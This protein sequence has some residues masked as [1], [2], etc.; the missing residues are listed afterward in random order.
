MTDFSCRTGPTFLDGVLL[1]AAA[2][3]DAGLV[4]RGSSCVDE[5]VRQSL[6]P[7]G[8]AGCLETL[9]HGG[10]LVLTMDP[11]SVS[12]MGTEERV[13]RGVE[14]LVARGGIRLVLLATLS[15]YHLT[16][17][18]LGPL[19]G[20]LDARLPDVDVQALSTRLL[21]RDHHDAFRAFY[22]GL[23]ARLVA[24]GLETPIP[25]TVGI[26]GAPWLRDG[27]DSRGDIEELTRLVE[28]LGLTCSGVLLDGRPSTTFAPVA[29]AD[30][31]VAF[32]DAADAAEILAGA[33]GAGLLRCAV[34]V[35]LDDC[36]A[37]LLELARRTGREARGQTLVEDELRRVVPLLDSVVPGAL[38]G[39]RAIVAATAEWLPS[40]VRCLQEDL[41]MVVTDALARTRRGSLEDS[42]T[43]PATLHPD[44]SVDQ[45]NAAIDAART[46]GGVDVIIGSNWERNALEAAH[47]T[48]P[49]VEF[50]YP[51]QR[52]TFLRS[53][54]HL[55]Y[56][57]VLTWAERLLAAVK[58]V[59]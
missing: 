35:S 1:V 22:A 15:R 42:W 17:E 53:T 13:A 39:R 5:R 29:G 26:L 8:G 46:R 54:P 7:H 14:A 2:I 56:S 34:P 43:G 18:R 3:P 24:Q 36:G 50:G 30:T 11:Y 37:W 51:Q 38:L 28:G 58:S 12:V 40:L 21:A 20:N 10:R 52:S 25:G 57:G 6:R 31:L 33:T 59:P 16:G 19:A 9:E 23:A 32:P 48:I 45:L 44:A 4:F 55:G 47:R 49:F 27:G 41:G